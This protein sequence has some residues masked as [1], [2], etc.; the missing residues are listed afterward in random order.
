MSRI[1]KFQYAVN[2][3]L[4]IGNVHNQLGSS[5]VDDTVI[6][7]LENLFK[8]ELENFLAKTFK[9]VKDLKTEVI[10]GAKNTPRIIVFIEGGVVHDVMSDSPAQVRI[11]DYDV[12]GSDKVKKIRL[13]EEDGKS[14][15]KKTYECH[16]Y[17]CDLDGVED[18]EPFFKQRSIK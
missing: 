11:I 10:G 14:L 1:Q 15:S 8:R 2:I 13:V 4:P 17:K 7:N 3:D 18:L 9:K 6:P 5:L 16:I 12:E